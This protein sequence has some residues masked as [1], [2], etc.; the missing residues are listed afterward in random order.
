MTAIATTMAA[1][2]TGLTAGVYLAFSTMM[3]PALDGTSP[4]RAL[5]IMRRINDLAER[6][7]F[8]IVFLASTAG[9]V[10][11]LVAGWLPEGDRDVRTTAAALLSLAAFAITVLFHVPRNRQTA[12]LDRDCEADLLRWQALSGQ[13]TRGNHLRAGC[14]GAALAV[15]L[16]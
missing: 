1:L 4:A 7:V 14:A 12:L 13:W 8:L 3:M 11:L 16:L 15:F 10:W 9:S 2:C 5:M 6:P